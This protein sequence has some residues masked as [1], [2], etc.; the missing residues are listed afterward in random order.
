MK[1]SNSGFCAVFPRFRTELLTL[2][3][4]LGPRVHRRLVLWNLDVGIDRR[5]H[6]SQDINDAETADTY[7]MLKPTLLYL[8]CNHQNR[9]LNLQ[10]YFVLAASICHGTKGGKGKFVSFVVLVPS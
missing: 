2:R 3:N 8:Y 4:G 10:I 9:P 5:S 7:L 1:A 6:R